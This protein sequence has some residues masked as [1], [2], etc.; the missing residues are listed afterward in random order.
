MK[1]S[2]TKER[3]TKLKP[4]RLQRTQTARKKQK[5]QPKTVQAPQPKK[6]DTQTTKISNANYHLKKLLNSKK[7]Q[8]DIRT[9]MH[10]ILNA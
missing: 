10:C 3:V 1:T 5:K 9:S 8:V 6:I 7:P 2:T 4:I